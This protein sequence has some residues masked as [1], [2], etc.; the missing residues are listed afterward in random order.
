M[1]NK[2]LILIVAASLSAIV[3]LEWLI[4]FYLMV[5]IRKNDKDAVERFMNSYMGWKVGAEDIMAKL[6]R[7]KMVLT[8]TTAGSIA[9]SAFAFA[10]GLMYGNHSDSSISASFYW[11]S[12][13]LLFSGVY[14]AALWL[15]A[16]SALSKL[17]EDYSVAE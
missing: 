10:L 13:F 3:L 15:L 1:E 16:A 2:T 11:A 12:G 9:V 8:V 6:S 17:A 4:T 7:L 5:K 14:C